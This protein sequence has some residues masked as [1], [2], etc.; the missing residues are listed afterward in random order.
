MRFRR[1]SGEGDGMTTTTSSTREIVMEGA[2]DITPLVI[3]V[4]PY[5]L[6]IG[7]VV[8]ASS[9]PTVAGWVSGPLIFAGT[10]QLMVIQMLE[11]GAA[12]LVIVASALLVNARLLIYGVGMSSW[13][14]TTSR[15]RRLLLAAPLLDQL[16]LVMVPRF[17]RGDLDER[18]RQAYYAGAAA[19]LVVAWSTAQLIGVL[20]GTAVPE[21]VGLEVAAPVTFAGL[22]ARAASKRATSWVAAVAAAVAVIA[23][24]LPYR[25]A[26][27]VAVV[28][29]VIVGCV[30]FPAGK[31]EDR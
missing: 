29:G 1:R 12:P 19:L 4:I 22:L 23:A 5:A 16:Y 15:R 25:T 18:G 26:T 24:Y 11:A 14:S 17:E 3:A 10:P 20:A 2:R 30:A 21:S 9:V 6:A 28:V 31:A 13:F 27:L 7:A 8:G